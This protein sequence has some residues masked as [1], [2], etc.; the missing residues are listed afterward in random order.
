MQ[1]EI[2]FTQ[3]TI[4]GS[5]FDERLD[6]ERLTGQL[7]AIY[8][9]MK[10]GRFKTLSEISGATLAPESSVSAQLRNMRK[11]PYYFT[12]EKQRRGEPTQ[13]LWEYRLSV[14]NKLTLQK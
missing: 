13:G 1:T 14:V 6:R 3:A 10:D 9:F 12:V 5:N 7:K 4:Q 11:K 8:E 2:D